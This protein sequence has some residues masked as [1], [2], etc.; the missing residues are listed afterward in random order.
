MF[1]NL[2]CFRRHGHNEVDNPRF[3]NPRLYAV[4]DALPSV[5]DTYAEQLVEQGVLEQGA[6]AALKADFAEQLGQALR[7]VDEGQTAPR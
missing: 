6:A 5:A 7:R 1:I 2:L 4:V 3:T